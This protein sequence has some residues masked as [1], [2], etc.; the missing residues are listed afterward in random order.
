[1]KKRDSRFTLLYAFGILFVLAS[2]SKNGGMNLFY[3]WFPPFSFHLPLFCF[4]SGYFFNDRNTE[5]IAAFCLRKAKQLLVPLYVWNLIYGLF[6]ELL[7]IFGFTLTKRIT[8]YRLLISPLIDGH[9]FIFNLGSWF[10]APLFMIHVFN[11][12]FRKLL[13]AQGRPARELFGFVFYLVLG[14]LDTM[15]VDSGF[16]E[17][18]WL[19]LN[20]MLYLLPF[21]GFGMFYRNVLEK[22]DQKISSLPYYCAVMGIQLVLIIYTDGP[23]EYSAAWCTEYGNAP[24]LPFLYGMTGIAFWLR[25][26]SLLTPVIGDSKYVRLIG[27][28]TKSIATHHYLGF[29]LLNTIYAFVV[30][31][32]HRFTYFDMTEFHTSVE[33]LFRPW[34]LDHTLVLY[35]VFGLAVS[36]VIAKLEKKLLEKLAHRVHGAP[37]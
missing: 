13:N 18:P 31:V 1:M 36:L 8:W 14:I 23:M 12:F 26:A 29:F 21:Y 3:S 37:I 5:H 20:R 7:R 27:E 6:G 11:V 34:L 22:Y 30:N 33:Y 4:C 17:L 35:P 32:T 25:T 15:F 10:F 24:L 2:H 19:V 16:T 9:A 28:N